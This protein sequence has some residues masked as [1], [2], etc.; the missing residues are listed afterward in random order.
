MIAIALTAILCTVMGYG[1]C[2]ILTVGKKYDSPQ[3]TC[4]PSNCNRHCIAWNRCDA[5][6]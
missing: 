2:A 3:N 5:K 1:L 6:W 4:K